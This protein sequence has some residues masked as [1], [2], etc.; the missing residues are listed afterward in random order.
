MLLYFHGENLEMYKERQRPKVGMEK[1][2]NLAQ[3]QA[4]GKKFFFC[5]SILLL[6]EAGLKPGRHFFLT[7][8]RWSIMNTDFGVIS[9]SYSTYFACLGYVI[10]HLAAYGILLYSLWIWFTLH[11]ISTLFSRLQPSPNSDS[12]CAQIQTSKKCANLKNLI[13]PHQ[14]SKSTTL[15]PRFGLLQ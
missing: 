14:K 11:T 4:M 7:S 13:P 9:L 15:F 5:Q 3:K 12:S 8:A 10:C 6:H 2:V 1:P